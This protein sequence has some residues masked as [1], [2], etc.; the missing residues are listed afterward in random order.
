M[1]HFTLIFKQQQQ[2]LTNQ[3]IK[4]IAKL[5]HY[6]C[7]LR[8]LFYEILY[9]MQADHRN[10]DIFLKYIAKEREKKYYYIKNNVKL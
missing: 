2:Q 9:T 6:F 3:F 8:D 1:L 4:Y 5:Q 10:N 7:C